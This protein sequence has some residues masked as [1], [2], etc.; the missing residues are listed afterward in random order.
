MPRY[1]WLRPHLQ[2][3]L[4]E[5]PDRYWLSYQIVNR[6]R[7]VHPEILN[8][9]EHDHGIGQGKGG[10]EPEGAHFRPDSAVSLCLSDWGHSVDVQYLH[11]KGLKV[12]G[13]SAAAN[14]MG[15]FRWRE[16]PR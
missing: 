12:G 15:I 7:E 2:E 16:N 3:I 9:L 1:E 13:A 14:R 11:G 5:H 8:R 10:G 4:Q 6:L